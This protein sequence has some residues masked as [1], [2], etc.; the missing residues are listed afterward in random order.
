MFDS[1][2]SRVLQVVFT[3]TILSGCNGTTTNVTPD[4]L[5]ASQ[6]VS[7][8]NDS[9]NDSNNTTNNLPTAKGTATLNWMP[10]T[11]NNDNTS[12]TDLTGY[13]IYY[14]DSPDSLVN[15]IQVQSPGIASYVVENLDVNT[16]Y[17]FSITAVNSNNI[18][19]NYSNIVSKHISS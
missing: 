7:I 16:T 2:T 11:E 1:F 13:V 5:S 18:Q 4:S 8:T 14:G 19:S 12:L 3:I 6:S 9:N 17:Y 10:P 15:K